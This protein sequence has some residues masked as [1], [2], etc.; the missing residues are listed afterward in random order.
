MPEL[1]SGPLSLPAGLLSRAAVLSTAAVY[2]P[3]LTPTAPSADELDA[4]AWQ[5]LFLSLSNQVT[6]LTPWC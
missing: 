1:V 6:T 4:A 3:G 2:L 5:R